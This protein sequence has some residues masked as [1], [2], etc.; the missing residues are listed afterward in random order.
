MSDALAICKSAIETNNPTIVSDYTLKLEP[1]FREIKTALDKK[2]VSVNASCLC[3]LQVDR[4]ASTLIFQKQI[5]RRRNQPNSPPPSPRTTATPRRPAMIRLA[6]TA[7]RLPLAALRP[8]SERL[9][10][11]AEAVST[12]RS[13]VPSV[14]RRHDET[15][16]HSTAV[17]V[18]QPPV[19][20]QQPIHSATRLALT[21]RSLRTYV[22]VF[23][24]V[25][26]A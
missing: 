1:E 12:T 16:I 26:V 6:P 10:T 11:A 9:A 19:P 8:I 13:A 17:A 21:R 24:L 18:T 15:M 25:V 23:C 5:I 4:L 20:Q 7:D 3:S 22:F 14:V 2:D